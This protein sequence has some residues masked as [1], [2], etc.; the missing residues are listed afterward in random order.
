MATPEIYICQVFE[1]IEANVKEVDNAGKLD[2]L[3]ECVRNFY[4][5]LFTEGDQGKAFYSG[6]SINLF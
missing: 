5:S 6:L 1:S 4:V 2:R 3:V